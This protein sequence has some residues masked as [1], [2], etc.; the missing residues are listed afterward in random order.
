MPFTTVRD[1][2]LYYELHGDGPATLAI[3]GSG[4]DLRTSRPE[5]SPLNREL[6]V[7]HYDQRGLGRTSP[8]DHPPTMADFADDAAALLD[9]VGWPSAHVVGTS[10]G[11]MVALEL[12]LRHPD[13]VE[14]LV[15]NCTSPGGPN[16]SYPIHELQE[17]PPG[18]RL[19]AWLAVLDDRYDP[20]AEEPVP[21]LGAF[22]GDLRTRF[23]DE[24]DEASLAGYRAQLEARRHHDVVDRLGDIAAPTLVCAGRHDAIAPLPNAEL[25]A[26]SIPDARL[27]IFDG[28][29]LFL[30]QDRRAFT[31]IRAH[32]TP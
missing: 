8:G 21:G 2:R 15:L 1:L 10:F 27:E 5:S 22:Y 23:L 16:P 31:T 25:L 13:R 3:S 9:D 24:R 12:A 18:D 11:G 26:R 17:L 4:G 14:R 6:R 19:E 28:G 32:L 20:G 30:L 29:H 7:L